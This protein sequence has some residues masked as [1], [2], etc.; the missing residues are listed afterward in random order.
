[1][2]T[3]EV[4]I[5]DAV[6]GIH[7]AHVVGFM[8]AFGLVDLSIDN[9]GTFKNFEYTIAV[10]RY[11]LDLIECKTRSGQMLTKDEN[12]FR[13]DIRKFGEPGYDDDP[14]PNHNGYFVY[15]IQ[16]VEKGTKLPKEVEGF[17]GYHVY[18]NPSKPWW[19]FW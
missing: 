15:S 2:E 16:M 19:K 9:V 11:L 10:H 14:G 3:T 4:Q 17:I 8:S 6:R 7:I 12:W 13:V 18:S 1:M 5:S